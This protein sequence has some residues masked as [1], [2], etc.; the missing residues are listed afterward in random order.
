MISFGSQDLAV[1][2]RVKKY[3]DQVLQDD[4]KI[5]VDY[6]TRIQKHTYYYRVQRIPFVGLF[7]YGFGCCKKSTGKK[8][9][10][11]IYSSEE[12]IRRAFVEG[13]LEGDGNKKKDRRYS[14]HFVRCDTNSKELACGLQYL[15]KSIQHGLTYFIKK[16][17]HVGWRYRKDKPLVSSLRVQSAKKKYSNGNIA[18]AQ[19]KEIKKE[20]YIG[21]VYDIEV[22]NKH[23]FVDAEGFILVHNTDS[24][25][26]ILEDKI[27]DQALEFM[28]EINQDLPGQMELELEGY[29]PKG[30]FVAIKGMEKG[31]L[32]ARLSGTSTEQSV[33]GAKKKYALLSQEGKL[34]VTGFEA[35]RRNWSL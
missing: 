5:I 11:F 30:I 23:N 24:M 32:K 34:K 29:Y 8:V 26:I 25:F 9:P 31:S 1:I 20:Q 13:Y 15:F 2:K 6:D 21:P 33:V 17:N 19:I 7:L 28:Q 22:E 4:L 18:G 27:R 12:K 35:V 10:S 14:T 16:I 3:F